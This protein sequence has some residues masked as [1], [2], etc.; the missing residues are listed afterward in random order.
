V[1]TDRNNNEL[2]IIYLATGRKK[3]CFPVGI[4]PVIFYT[5]LTDLYYNMK[6]LLTFIISLLTFSA[7]GQELVKT[8]DYLP[9][10]FFTKVVNAPYTIFDLT[11]FKDKPVIIAF[12]GTWCAPCIPEMMQLGK[13]QTQFGDKVQILA[14][15]NDSEQKIKDFLQK[16]PSKIWFASDPS[17]NLWNLFN[18]E[19]AGHAVIV[20]RNNKLAA[21][22]ET[23]SI[24]SS[25]IK[26]LINGQSL[27]LKEQRGDKKLSA[28]EIPFKADSST[29][30][31]FTL[32]PAIDGIVP[33]MKKPRT[34]AFAE[35]RITIINL[36]PT[37]ILS[38]AFGISISRRVF[39]ASKEDS[40]KS[41]QTS[42]C[43]DLIVSKN[44]KSNLNA[45]FEKEVN[46]HLPVKGKIQKRL[47]SCYVLRPAGGQQL[48]MKE[49]TRSANQFSFNG[50]EFEGE[51]IP[52]RTF[53]KYLE[54]G[55]DYPVY[56]ATG[57]TGYYDIV[58]SKNN[59]E[60]LKSTKEGL[61]KLGFELVKDQKEM[62]V[63]VISGQ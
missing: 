1:F 2:L 3:S 59:I 62:E 54:N 57:M 10:Y 55:L 31:S 45:F 30:Y 56:D 8:G 32:H 19:V 60:P 50:L 42:L 18:I 29:L 53:I 63:L 15:S 4:K 40:I 7:F 13:L 20:D 24:D 49:S 43:L 46:N 16:R 41:N 27:Q 5:T 39:Y 17:N 21:I 9:K 6:A 37:I 33:M 58:F 34:G 28:N 61:A 11:E 22:T 14:V 23:R 25:I 36:A 52:I 47:I 35:R 48:A 44:D 38:E 51:G 26:K 12:W